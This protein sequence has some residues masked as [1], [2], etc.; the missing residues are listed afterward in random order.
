MD[1]NTIDTYKQDENPADRRIAAA[2]DVDDPKATGG[3]DGTRIYAWE[4]ENTR[5]GA[6]E[7]TCPRARNASRAGDGMRARRLIAPSAKTGHG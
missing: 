5:A 4:K 3:L 6:G 2:D 1:K 7:Y